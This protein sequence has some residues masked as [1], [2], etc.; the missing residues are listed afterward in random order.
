MNI[1]KTKFLKQKPDIFITWSYVVLFKSQI[2]ICWIKR[3]LSDN[4]SA[5]GY[6]AFGDIDNLL[7]YKQAC[8]RVNLSY[9]QQQVS[10]LVCLM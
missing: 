6:L 2:F 5:F 8:P 10:S 3:M 1:L 4:L 9:S 7:N